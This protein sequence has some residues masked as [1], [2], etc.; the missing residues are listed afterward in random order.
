VWI[1]IGGFLRK[2]GSVQGVGINDANYLVQKF[3][4]VGGKNKLIWRCPFYSCWKH[5]LKRCYDDCYIKLHPTYKG[6]SVCREWHLFSNFKSWMEQQDWEE[7]QLD[8]D[9]LVYGNK[10]YSP[11][12]CVF[13]SQGLNKFLTKSNKAR[14]EYP[15]G[16][17]KRKPC[18]SMINDFSKPYVAAC[19]SGDGKQIILVFLIIQLMRT[20][21]GR[22]PK[23]VLHLS[24]LLYRKM[25]Q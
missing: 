10:V 17:W 4:T 22:K 24:Y 9:L 7:K 23:L 3:T 5:M 14:G 13:L 12:T 11:S 2:R 1:N 21:L 18:A 25:K 20:R 15:L 6:C 19:G 16:V 8:K